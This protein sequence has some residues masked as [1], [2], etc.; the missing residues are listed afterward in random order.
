MQVANRSRRAGVAKDRRY[1]DGTGAAD[2]GPLAR[3]DDSEYQVG[4]VRLREPE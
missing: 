4:G 1:Y 3:L 2:L